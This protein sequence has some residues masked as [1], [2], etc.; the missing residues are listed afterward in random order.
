MGDLFYKDG[1][2][3]T[4]SFVAVGNC[5]QQI[6]N[7]LKEEVNS[8]RTPTISKATLGKTE[9]VAGSIDPASRSKI[10]IEP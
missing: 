4:K 5:Y 3:N 8:G 1:F 7:G 9:Y 6:A 2:G 10:K